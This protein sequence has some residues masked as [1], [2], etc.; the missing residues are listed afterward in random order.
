MDFN[1]VWN[2]F[3][4][5]CLILLILIIINSIL[6][7]ILFRIKYSFPKI[8][9]TSQNIINTQNDP[10]QNN[11]ADS[12]YIKAY[13]EKNIF[14]LKPQAEYSITGMVVTKNTNFWFRD[15]MRSTFDDI[16]L[17]D[18][19]IVWGELAKDKQK[20]YKNWKFK[21]LKTLGESRRL[22]WRSK[23]ATDAMPWSLS[24]VSSHI[25]H[26]HLIPANP[27]IM[28][29]LLRIKKNDIVKIDGYLVDI[30]TDKNEL[31]AKTS[32]SRTD[33]D[34]TSRGSGACEDM[35][36]KQVQ[37]NNKIYR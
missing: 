11:L 6:G 34:P 10:V 24:Y 7:D 25:S 15:I 36:V 19:G 30:Y 9:D 23:V 5:G 1:R 21:S 14:A 4:K 17:M 32:L 28:G 18:I 2:W 20:L 13:G 8:A 22:E 37:I 27:N 29:A 31:V 16:C 3:C 26:T 35:Y 12:N 33:T